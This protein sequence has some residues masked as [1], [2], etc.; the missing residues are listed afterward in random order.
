MTNPSTQQKELNYSCDH[1]INQ[2][3]FE[4][5]NTNTTS[6]KEFTLSDILERWTGSEETLRTIMIAKAEEDRLKQEI[7][8]LNI[9]KVENEILIN[10]VRSGVQ[11]NAIPIIFSGQQNNSILT[12]SQNNPLTSTS[13]IQY[14]LQN[15]GLCEASVPGCCPGT[16]GSDSISNQ[17]IL[18]PFQTNVSN[19]SLESFSTQSS[20]Q[21]NAKSPFMIP[22]N[23]TESTSNQSSVL[24]PNSSPLPSLFFHYWIPPGESINSMSTTN[25]EG[26]E[27]AVSSQS[28]ILGSHEKEILSFS[29]SKKKRLS[30]LQQ[31]LPPSFGNSILPPLSRRSPR[32]HSRHLSE[33]SIS[34][35][36]FFDIQGNKRA[37][38]PISNEINLSKSK[39]I[40]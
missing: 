40:N 29:P 24:N 16:Q 33:T 12:L 11:L 4:R 37:I 9:K 10:A 17:S 25:N 7:V 27:L 1:N 28:N 15:S 31:P 21:K 3:C 26:T 2:F 22:K 30:Q 35:S 20:L 34:Q 32:R 13:S 19:I 5:S 14:Q 23:T 38:S 8:R 36:N 6:N 18:H 39:N